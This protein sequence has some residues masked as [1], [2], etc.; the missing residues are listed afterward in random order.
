MDKLLLILLF[1]M[2]NY[3]CNIVKKIT[4]KKYEW[5][6]TEIGTKQY[7]M[8]ILKGHYKLEDDGTLGLIKGG[9]LR[10]N[11]GRLGSLSVTGDKYK[12]L[13]TQLSL[14]WFSFTE[15]KFFSGTATLPIDKIKA[16]FKEGFIS[17]SNDK[18]MHFEFI[19][20]GL[21]PNGKVVVWANGSKVTKEICVLDFKEKTDMVWEEFISNPNYPMKRY[22]RVMLEDVFKEKDFLALEKNGVDTL[23]YV[24]KY[25][26]HYLWGQKIVGSI[27]PISTL[28]YYYNGE[29]EYN[30]TNSEELLNRPIPIRAN[31]EWLNTRGKQLY[32]D[33]LF[34]EEEVFSAFQKF[35]GEHKSG[36]IQLEFEISDLTQDIRI[37][38]RN[39]TYVFEFKKC[40]VK[41]F[42]Q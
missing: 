17:P 11:W 19:I 36:N 20:L 28:Y 41:V 37:F 12:A 27:K 15:N 8:E 23:L 2:F 31:I 9:I 3:A 40:V 5:S 22:S 25:R 6:S 16:M 30:H 21:A 10:G 38:I 42:K 29:T 26:R 32:S 33:I 4:M 24:E 13:P 7:P 34:D 18:E 1:S 14:T 35:S 39:D